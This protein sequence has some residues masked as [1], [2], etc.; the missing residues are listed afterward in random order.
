MKFTKII[1]RTYDIKL[2]GTMK[3][4]NGFL[5]KF[6]KKYGFKTH[7]VCFMCDKKLDLDGPVILAVVKGRG[8]VQICEE[9]KN[10][11]LQ[12]DGDKG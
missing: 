12:E 10:K 1:T 6:R 7:T 11:I 5:I 2:L 8:N 3:M 9:C 4:S